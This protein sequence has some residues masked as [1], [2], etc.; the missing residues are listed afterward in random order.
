[1]NGILYRKTKKDIFYIQEKQ[2]FGYIVKVKDSRVF[3]L[4]IQSG[5]VHVIQSTDTIVPVMAIRKHSCLLLEP[6]TPLIK[7][8]AL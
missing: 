2:R 4:D 7:F 5:K 6:T 3:Y 8:F 1:M